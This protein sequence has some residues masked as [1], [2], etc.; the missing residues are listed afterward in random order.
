MGKHS[1]PRIPLLQRSHR[2]LL[3]TAL[4]PLVGVV[5]AAAA[6][7]TDDGA[8]PSVAAPAATSSVT[9]QPVAQSS[10]S[11]PAPASPTAV[12]PSPVAQTQT[13]APPAA[14]PLPASVTAGDVPAIN[15]RAYRAAADTIA[16]TQPT[17]GIDWKLVAGIGRVESH[18]ANNG[19]IAANGELKTPIFGPTL[20]GS[21]AGN[22]VITDTDGGALDGDSVHDRAVGPMQFIPST[23]KKYAADGNGDGVADPQNIFDAALTTARYLCDGHLDLRNVASQTTAVLRY[24]NSMT[25]VS[26]VLGYARGY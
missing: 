23:W 2:P 7:T 18:H 16:R 20:D 10:S 9:A 24:N 8:G 26:D 15:Y 3:A 21:L 11:T 4:V 1:K 19:D 25:Y 5:A 14:D 12:T 13:S 22:Q 6:A 17:C